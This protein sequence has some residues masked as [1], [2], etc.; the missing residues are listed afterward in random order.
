LI[1]RGLHVGGLL[2]GRL[3]EAVSGEPQGERKDG[4]YSCRQRDNLFVVFA[5]DSAKPAET[6]PYH[7]SERAIKGGAFIAGGVLCV[8]L[9][10]MWLAERDPRDRSLT[11]GPNR[12]ERQNPKRPPKH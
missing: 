1:D 12:Q 7:R 11:N 9:L 8:I 3:P 6:K 4:D 10:A 5:S 2:P